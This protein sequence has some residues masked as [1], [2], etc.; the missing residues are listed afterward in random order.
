MDDGLLGL[1][2]AAL[3][4]IFTAWIFLLTAK[5]LRF[6]SVASRSIL[7]WESPRPWFFGLCLGI[8]V[9]MVAMTFLSGFVLNRPPLH[10]VAQALM[11]VF[12]TVVF[13]LSFR[14]RKGF[15]ATGI[16]AER[17]F[18]PYQEIRWLGWKEEPE[19][20]LALRGED[21][22][23]RQSYDFLRGPGDYYGQAR[24][25]LADRIKDQSLAPKTSVLGL[26]SD[27]SAQERV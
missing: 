10:T 14:I 18:L 17:G 4:V 8:G 15:Y 25:I 1:A 2:F 23:F 7:S 21:R 11:A 19:I 24:R 9:F 13:P 27:A 6:R 20:I 5:Y 3:T 26:E 12:Y 22:F 16:W